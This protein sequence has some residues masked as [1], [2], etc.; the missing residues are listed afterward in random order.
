MRL[1]LNPYVIPTPA[2]LLAPF[3]IGRR[4][5]READ[6]SMDGVLNVGLTYNLGGAFAH[7]NA[8]YE[9]AGG[10]KI[11]G[12]GFKRP[13]LLLDVTLAVLRGA[14]NADV[15]TMVQ[16]PLQTLATKSRI[17]I[18]LETKNFKKTLAPKAV[19]RSAA[20]VP[21]RIRR[22]VTCGTPS[23][24]C[25]RGDQCEVRR[26]GE[27]DGH[28]DSHIQGL[29]GFGAF[30]LLTHSDKSKEAGRILVV[31]RRPGQ[32]KFVT[33]FRLPPLGTGGRDALNHAGGCQVI[34]DVLA[35]PSESGRNSSVVSF[36]DVSNPLKICELHSSLRITR[37]DRDASA[38]GITTITRKG[39]P[40]GSAGSMTAAPWT[41]TNR[42]TCRAVL[43]SGPSSHPQS[44]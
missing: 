33:E 20:V 18:E 27:L 40:C 22:S 24:R 29:A 15:L 9:L 36:F 17:V 39:Q 37:T 42:P 11:A 26:A 30:F 41:S 25:R 34:G 5:L 7:N 13:H 6:G 4:N 44:R 38:V 32:Q 10:D 16:P 21:R 8:F 2:W 31:D 23:M 43:H 28:G 1:N 14:S 3:P 35:V 19:S 12:G